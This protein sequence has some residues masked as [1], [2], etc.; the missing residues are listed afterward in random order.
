ME[1]NIT[2]PFV[3]AKLYLWDNCG[4]SHCVSF[5]EMP[6]EKTI[7]EEIGEWVTDDMIKAWR[8]IEETYRQEGRIPLPSSC[9]LSYQLVKEYKLPDS[10]QN[11]YQV[12][13]KEV[14]VYPE[15]IPSV[16]L[17]YILEN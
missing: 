7:Q 8:K 14:S 9:G 3:G 16:R 17:K 2:L 12:I 10:K 6:S 5:D 13:M 4:G 15:Q 1:E 11:A